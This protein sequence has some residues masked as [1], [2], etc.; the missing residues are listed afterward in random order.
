MGYSRVQ[1]N[2][3]DLDNYDPLLPSK[4]NEV[5]GDRAAHNSIVIVVSELEYAIEYIAILQIDNTIYCNTLIQQYNIL[6]YFRWT[7]Q[8]IA[9]L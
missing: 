2:P 3:P 5:G 1:L 9:I 4:G 7:I 6:Q 8:Y